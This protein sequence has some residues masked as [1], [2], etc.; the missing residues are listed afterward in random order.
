M[1]PMKCLTPSGADASASQS[2]QEAGQGSVS[3]ALR[4]PSWETVPSR[5]QS[6]Q[7][8]FF[9][10]FSLNSTSSNPSPA[11]RNQHF[12]KVPLN[13]RPSKQLEKRQCF[14]QIRGRPVLQPRSCAQVVTE[15]R[16]QFPSLH[17]AVPRTGERESSLFV[18][19]HRGGWRPNECFQGGRGKGSQVPEETVT[20]SDSWSPGGARD[21]S[22][23]F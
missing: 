23:R 14:L 10:F 6:P 2:G 19:G 5:V 7:G 21:E 22:L 18:G 3:G 17:S 11:H 15:V 8:Y 16:R 20:C 1:F 4:S 13:R 9:S 12:I